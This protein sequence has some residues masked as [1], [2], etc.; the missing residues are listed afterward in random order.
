VIFTN[1]LDNINHIFLKT[2]KLIAMKNSIFA[3][4]VILLTVLFSHSVSCATTPDEIELLDKSFVLYEHALRWQD[5]DI[6]IGFHKNEQA[7]LTAEKRKQLKKYRVTS[8]NVVFTK[9]APD[10]KSATQIVEIKYYNDE[11]SVVRDLTLTNK[12]VYD[13][14]KMHWQLTNPLPDFK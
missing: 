7:T 3:L 8:Y 5:Y 4:K 9:V 6:V 12:W 2:I 14:K 13:P 1:G 11:Y 10:N